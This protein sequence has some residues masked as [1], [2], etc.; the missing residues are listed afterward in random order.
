LDYLTTHTSLSPIRRGFAPGFVNYKKRCTRLATANDKDCQLLAHS[1]W[2]SPGTPVSSTTKPGRHDI[3]EIL[4]KVTLNTI[5]QIKSINIWWDSGLLIPFKLLYI[6]CCAFDSIQL[7][8]FDEVDIRNWFLPRRCRVMIFTGIVTLLPSTTKFCYFDY[9]VILKCHWHKFNAIKF[10][11][12][13]RM[14][15]VRSFSTQNCFRSW[16][17]MSRWTNIPTGRQ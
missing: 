10:I 15:T 1:R 11:Y 5:N 8:I 3:A 2:F 14:L 9:I 12:D 17:C 4:L 6:V 16:L 7:M 13:L